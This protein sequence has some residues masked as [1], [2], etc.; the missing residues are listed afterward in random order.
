M[1]V[2]EELS[3][4]S[5]GS[6]NSFELLETRCYLTRILALRGKFSDL[7]SQLKWAREYAHQSGLSQDAA[8]VLCLA[9]TI[10]RGIG[11]IDAARAAL[12]ELSKTPGIGHEPAYAFRLAE[13][14]RV[15]LQVG[16]AAVAGRLVEIC[17][18][19]TPVQQH[20]VR[21]TDAL[22]AE[23][24][25]DLETAADAFADAAA[26]WI[27]FGVPYE[28]AQAELGLSRCLYAQG[29]PGVQDH[30]AVARAIFQRLG[31]SPATSEADALLASIGASAS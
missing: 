18:G 25:G 2:G 14:V 29:R 5:E 1:T 13:M 19:L 9:V 17:E 15:A 8:I 23:H 30:L 12:T 7:A 31:A 11:D 4:W 26:R 20:A 28:E 10:N 22:L 16:V 27:H 21:T 24:R 6:E 3:V